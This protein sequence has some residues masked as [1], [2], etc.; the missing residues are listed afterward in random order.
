[1]SSD[2]LGQKQ[3]THEIEADRATW[4]PAPFNEIAFA[5]QTGPGY[6]IKILDMATRTVRQLTFGEGTNESP[7]FAPNGRHLAFISTRAGK[8]QIFVIGTRRQGPQADHQRQQQP[9][10]ELVAGPE[11][12]VI[13][14]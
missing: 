13:R 1:M 8:E 3:V 5:A 2:G 7:A 11:A 10:A 14:D 6:D 9:D 4:S 12:T